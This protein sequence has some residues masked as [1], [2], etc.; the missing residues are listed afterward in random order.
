[1]LA[2]AQYADLGELSWAAIATRIMTKQVTN[3]PQSE[4]AKGPC[5]ALAKQAC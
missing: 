1:V 3:R 2:D 4:G 5:R